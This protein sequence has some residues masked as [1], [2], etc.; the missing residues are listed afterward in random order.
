METVKSG[1][2]RGGDRDRA[3]VLTPHLLSSRPEFQV[4]GCNGRP[5]GGDP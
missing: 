1:V 5:N 4:L 2:K 3:S